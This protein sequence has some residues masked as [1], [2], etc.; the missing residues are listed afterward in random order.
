MDNQR[1]KE[2]LSGYRPGDGAETDPQVAEALEQARRDPELG[3]WLEQ[4]ASFDSAIR[5]KLKQIAVPAGLKARILGSP[6]GA[7]RVAEPD[8]IQAVMAWW[9]RPAFLAAAALIIF[10][11]AVLGLFLRPQHDFNAYRRQMTGFVSDEYKMNVEAKDLDQL[12]QAFAAKGWP[13][14]YTFPL[15][16]QSLPLEGG[17]TLEWQG[18]K[19]SLICWSAPGQ[20][21]K[22]EKEDK[23]ES[24]EK[25][26]KDTW[27]FIADAPVSPG[28]PA[29]VAPQFAKV[30]ELATASWSK[31]GKLYI[32]AARNDL[33]SLQ[34][35]F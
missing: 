10:A 17:V 1:A 22:G 9:R 31:D 34:K 2:I 3:R 15:A 13:S 28:A 20:E 6:T 35:Y 24:E 19:V 4:Q 18:H 27:L 23:D 5:A 33:E 7:E 14:E 16:L 26:E 29:D 21:E 30:G 8:I 25:D 12:R 11:C 32:L